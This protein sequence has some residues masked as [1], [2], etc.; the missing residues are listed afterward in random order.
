MIILQTNSCTTNLFIP[1][2]PSRPDEPNV[3]AM[4]QL[5]TCTVFILSGFT[6]SAQELDVFT[7]PRDDRV[8]LTVRIGDQVWMAE[9]LNFNTSSA[10]AIYPNNTSLVDVFGRMYGWEEAREVC[11]D[12]WHL[13]T[14]KDW[15]TLTGQLGGE[16]LAG[17]KM[18]KSSPNWSS[19][20][21]EATN[22]SGFSV[23]PGG[24][25]EDPRDASFPFMGDM[26]F[27][28]TDAEKS[29]SDAWFR[30]LQVILS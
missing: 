15:E 20:N 25:L 13:P 30:C 28:W 2:L 19:G 14:E 7:D 18:K 16:S 17:N 21:E 24:Y 26:G 27:F 23:L 12:G 9:N 5:A 22:E 8:Y 10:K 11:P 6:L 3:P 4:K 29:K 1:N